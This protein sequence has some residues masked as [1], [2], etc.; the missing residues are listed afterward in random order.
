MAHEIERRI[1]RLRASDELSRF[2]AEL[3]VDVFRI[4]EC[5]A[6][7]WAPDSPLLLRFES[8]DVLVEL[9]DGGAARM[10]PGPVD[11]QRAPAGDDA[12]GCRCWLRIDRAPAE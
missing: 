3:L 6:E 4:W 12:D 5:E 2:R 7:R 10:T 8:D 9:G 11:T 1:H